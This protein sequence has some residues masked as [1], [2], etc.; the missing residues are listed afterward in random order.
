MDL[1]LIISRRLA[2]GL[3]TVLF[4]SLLVFAG[5][6]LLPGDVAQ[7][8]LGQG[9][10]PEL[11]ANVHA[12]LGLDQP[13]LVRYFKWLGNL[14]TGEL[15]TSLANGREITELMSERSGNTFLL[16]SVTA[17]VAVPLS[18]LLGLIAATKPNGKVDKVISGV[19]LTLISIPDFLVAVILVS[20]F[21]VQLGWLPAL[22]TLRPN[23]DFLQ[24]ART[25]A[26]PVT[27]L[28]FT[29]LAHMS[30]M[31]RTAVINVLTTP[32]IEMA[33]LKGVPKSRILLIHAL[34]NAIAPIINVIA[35]N[36]AYLISGVVVIETLF[37]LNGLGKLMVEAV[38]SRDVPL[39]QGC[40][41][42]FCAIYVLLNL[43]ADTV[44][45]LANPRIRHP[46]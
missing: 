39:V 8:I 10:T 5:T 3:V 14:V 28:S 37:N 26:L 11:I 1:F 15:G 41:M 29:I 19:T 34:L 46:K 44:S 36:L 9:A 21:S 33:I 42:L 17:L 27:A 6:E 32:A 20:I 25:L 16:A 30:R 13:I 31:T 12:R 38:T 2:I 35:L 22:S 7:A 45:I 18:I 24:I 23:S 40:A 43:F 4:V